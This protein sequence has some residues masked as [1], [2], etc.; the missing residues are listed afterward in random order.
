METNHNMLTEPTEIK[1][2]GFKLLDEFFKKHNWYLCKND[3]NWI[4]YTSPSKQTDVFDIII[5]KTTI[6]VSV[7]L[8]NSSYNYVTRF[9]NYFL[10]SEYI[11][12][13]L[14]DLI[15]V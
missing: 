8:K 1:N 12:N 3:I 2:K 13:R 6:H 11:E 4:Q 10:A 7:P 15:S 9:D 14:T 5:D